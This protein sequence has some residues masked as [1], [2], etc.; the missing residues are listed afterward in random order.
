MPPADIR[1]RPESKGG[2]LYGPSEIERP[3]SALHSGD[4]R[5]ESLH[6]ATPRP[7]HG[8]KHE[9][10]STYPSSSTPLLSTGFPL[11]TPPVG[12]HTLAITEMPIRPRAP[13]AGSFSSSLVLKAP[14][15]PLVHAA[16]NTDLDFSSRKELCDQQ[17]TTPNSIHLRNT[18]ESL[19]SFQPFA[20]SVFSH[21]PQYGMPYHQR[22]SGCCYNLQ[23]ASSFHAP[24]RHRRQSSLSS[25]NPPLRHA[26]M[27]GSYEESILRG[28]MSTSPSKPLGFTAQIG[29]LGKGNCKSSLKCPP[30]VSVHFPAVFYSYSSPG[31]GRSILDDTPS[32]YVGFI[33]LE[34]SLQ[35]PDTDIRKRRRRNR[36]FEDDFYFEPAN[37]ITL[38]SMSSIKR[39]REKN[40]PT[41][42]SPPGG[43][44]RI[45][46]Q[47]QLQIVIKNPH[48]TAVKL[49]LVPYDLDNMEP[50]TKTFVRQRSYSVDRI[51]DEPLA[52][53]SPA[54]KELD[55]KPILRYLIHLNICCP[56][57]GRFYLYSGIRVVFANRVPD[58]KEHLRNELQYPEP[59]YSPWK[60]T[61]KESSSNRSFIKTPEN[62]IYRQGNSEDDSST[63]FPYKP[64]LNFSL[65]SQTAHITSGIGEERAP[66]FPD[67]S[68]IAQSTSPLKFPVT[69]HT[70][71]P[72][73]SL[74]T[75][76]TISPLTGE[77]VF[78]NATRY[79]DQHAMYAPGSAG[80][81]QSSSDDYF[82]DDV[83]YRKMDYY[84]GFPSQAQ[85]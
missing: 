52:S 14:T 46:Q 49:F 17:R 5:D 1:E 73:D 61:S 60:P 11:W 44:Y 16:N 69:S 26:S 19:H 55:E 38:D 67:K 59:R 2:I 63:N 66:S 57:K 7:A 75:N 77:S 68:P 4:F 50:G 82:P 40:P 6:Q 45:P 43:C 83:F 65:H 23:P 62:E 21:S 34:T 28:W 29:V 10:P 36:N 58:G 85:R 56:S 9:S 76:D 24:A 15:S 51:I 78:G 32:P 22:T 20:R 25:E 42:K 37:M 41:P 79:K 48:K 54:S 31:G 30:H 35:N 64:S 72:S 13:S 80:F 47:G 27:V 39:K 12:N 81:G 33:D 8:V 71:I 84:D 74:T 70:D 53:R 3:R 18:S